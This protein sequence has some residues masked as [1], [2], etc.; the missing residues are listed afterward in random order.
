MPTS[1]AVITAVRPARA[2]PSWRPTLWPISTGF[3][4][5]MP[6]STERSAVAVASENSASGRP[7]VS[8]TSQA[9]AVS[10]PEMPISA[11][12]PGAGRLRV[13]AKASSVAINSS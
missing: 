3:C 4:P 1:S 9:S 11:I 7:I 13:T 12:L 6:G 2:A 10:P 8:Q 5:G